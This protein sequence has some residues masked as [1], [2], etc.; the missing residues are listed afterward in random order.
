MG[1]KSKRDSIAWRLSL[2]IAGITIA[3][4][5]VASGILMVYDVV[6]FRREMARQATVLA[7]L[8]G[9]QSVSPLAFGDRDG[10]TEILAALAVDER[11]LRA[12]LYARTSSPSP[13]LRRRSAVLWMC[14]PRIRQTR[15]TSAYAA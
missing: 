14:A 3:A 6:S 8:V 12:C 11:V 7:D 2:T 1:P 4:V 5:V 10:A 13:I 15:S 9:T